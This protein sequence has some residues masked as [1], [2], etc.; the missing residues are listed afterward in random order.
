PRDRISA[1]AWR[2]VRQVYD[3]LSM[4]PGPSPTARAR[5]A[6][7]G[8]APPLAWD[9]DTIDDP[10]ALPDLGDHPT[11]PLDP[12]D[13]DQVAVDR[14]VSAAASVATEGKCD[15][16]I[17]LTR[18]E[19]TAAVRTL[20]ARG[21]SDREVATAVGVSSRTVLRIREQ[22][23]ISTAHPGGIRRPDLRGPMRGPKTREATA[24]NIALGGE[25]LGVGTDA[26]GSDR[27]RRSMCLAAAATALDA[28]PVAGPGFLR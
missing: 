14:V 24:P 9:D 26:R 12:V 25:A 5:A 22:Q 11:H 8:Y 3:R 16:R 23:G 19:V 10:R 20:T 27:L 17:R 4:T 28:R 2:Q 13:V 15:T 21:A 7:R 1:R 18:D 6:A